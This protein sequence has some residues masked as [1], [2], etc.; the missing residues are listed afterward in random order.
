[1]ES[2][3]KEA[4]TKSKTLPSQSNDNLLALYALYKQATEGDVSGSKPGMF[5]FKGVAK[6]NA[7][8]SKKGMTKE[9]AMQEYIE[10]VNRLGS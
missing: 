1:M 7:W 4:V 9:V 8:E 10:L 6:Y 2:Q 5:D 3:F